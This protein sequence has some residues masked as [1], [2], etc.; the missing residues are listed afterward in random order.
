MAKKRHATNPLAGYGFPTAAE[1]RQRAAALANASL[2]TV[3]TVSQPYERAMGDVANY[4]H[5]GV[6]LVRDLGPEVA[7]AYGQALDQQRAIDAA[8]Q[9]RLGEIGGATYG[10]GLQAAQGGVGDSAL[11]ALL[12]ESAASRN[13]M[14]QQPGIVSSRGQLASLGLQQ[15]L[16][17]ALQQRQD[18]SRT[19]STST[20]ACTSTSSRPSAPPRTRDH[21][22]GSPRTSA[23][24]C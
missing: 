4:T 17:D 10:A 23:T 15:S 20:L 6:G 16:Q 18:A 3:R 13:Y 12:A 24:R 1:L 21:G 11:S 2:P 19:T 22:V 5:A 9:Q 14:A 8:A 7:D